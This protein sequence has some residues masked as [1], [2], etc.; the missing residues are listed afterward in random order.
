MCFSVKATGALGESL[1]YFW[2]TGEKKHSKTFLLTQQLLLPTF[3]NS[4][5]LKQEKS[6]TILTKKKNTTLSSTR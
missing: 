3:H 5:P 2:R 4:N 1:S 6:S